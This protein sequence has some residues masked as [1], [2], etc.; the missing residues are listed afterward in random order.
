[1]KDLEFK[2]LNMAIIVK[3]IQLESANQ[4]LKWGVQDHTIWEWLG[5]TTEE[6]G[7]FAKAISEW[8]YRDGEAVDIIKE[9]IQTIT[10][11]LKIIEMV[12]NKDSKKAVE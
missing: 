1:M 6:F 7:E 4:V 9:G 5:Y 11:I 12:N 3:S 2:T 10:L 8:D